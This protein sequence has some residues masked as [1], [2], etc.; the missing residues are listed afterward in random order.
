MKNNKRNYFPYQENNNSNSDL[1]NL[2]NDI[3]INIIQKKD[4]D[5]NNIIYNEYTP[6]SY[7]DDMNNPIFDKD[8]FFLFKL[9]ISLILC[10]IYL[11]L[12]LINIP[13]SPIR[14]GEE[15][16]INLFINTNKT[17][18]LHILINYERLSF[19]NKTNDDNNKNNSN[20]IYGYLLDFKIDKTYVVRWL[21]GFLYFVVRNLCFV[22]SDTEKRNNN[23]IFR[24]N[25]DIINK[26]ACLIFPLFLFYYDIKNNNYA[27]I[28]IKTEY[29]MNKKINYY[30]MTNRHSSMNDYIEGIIPT[31]FYFLIS[32]IYNGMENSLK[33]L[34]GI[35]RKITK[36]V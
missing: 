13:N 34:F 36:L 3:E 4:L 5:Y 30:I 18:N 23:F 9:R 16:G 7:N 25:I 12:F 29:I 19:F 11:I 32:I 28:N 20:E 33:K 24:N 15:K 27:F 14:T 35:K 26:F 1:I 8:D 31:L 17:Q 21:I 6:K 10:T 22:Y 2:K